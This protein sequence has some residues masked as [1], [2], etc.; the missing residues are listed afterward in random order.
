M[1]KELE[2][3]YEIFDD[4]V[5]SLYSYLDHL[6][7]DLK[8]FAVFVSNQPPPWKIQRRKHMTERD[9]YF[10]IAPNTE[11]HQMFAIVRRYVSW[12][13]YELVD[14]I[15]RRYGNPDLKLKMKNYREELANFEEHTSAEVLKNIEFAICQPDSVALLA[16]LPDHHPNQLSVGD[17]SH[18]KH[19]IS[20]EA[21]VKKHAIRTF[22]IN[23]S[24]VEIIFLVPMMLAPYIIVSCSSN[25]SP[26]LKT[27]GPLPKDIYERAVYRMFTEEVF[28]LMGV[29]GNGM[30]ISNLLKFMVMCVT[31]NFAISLQKRIALPAT[32]N[33]SGTSYNQQ[34]SSSSSQ[35][36]R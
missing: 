19:R 16:I 30:N 1:Q 3:L 11:F 21:G 35:V 14:S 26:I 31:D 8:E 6:K 33:S 24:S 34:V 32:Q 2:H 29:S 18:L 4:L 13:N 12:H 25:A 7:P 27:Q 23:E 9:F 36:F 5:M 17:V 28:S 10:M 20:E 22:Q 15:V